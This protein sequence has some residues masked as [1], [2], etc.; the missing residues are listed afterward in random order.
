MR[1]WPQPLLVCLIAIRLCVL[2]AHSQQ[3]I[4]PTTQQSSQLAAV[5]SV[6]TATAPAEPEKRSSADYVEI[7]S[8]YSALTANFGSWSTGYTRSVIAAGN[9]VFSGEITGQHEFGDFG[10]YFD[11]GDTHNFGSNYYASLTVGSSVGGFFLPRFRGD[12]FLNKKWMGRKQLVTTAGF[13]Y[14]GAKDPHRNHTVYLG[15]AYY[16]EE[17]WILEDGVY[18]NVSSPGSVFSPS[19]F[20]AITQGRNKQHYLTLRAGYG[21]EAYQLIG[22]SRELSDFLSRTATFTWR[23]WIGRNWG[24]NCIADYYGNPYYTRGGSSVGVFKE[25]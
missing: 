20:L 15:T 1:I 19:G 22:P 7:G 10:T 8:S 16:F 3:I 14:S 5:S 12:G 17:P 18:L 2:N 4:A 21:Q 9:D 13:G 11:V 24:I 25:F 23:Q 6:V